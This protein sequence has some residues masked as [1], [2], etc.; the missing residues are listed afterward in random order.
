MFYRIAQES[1]NNVVKY[2]KATQVVV[3]LHM[4]E[5]GLRLSIMDDG[6]GFDVAAVPPNHL[7]LRIMRERADAVG[8]RWSIYSQPGEGTQVT[9]AWTKSESQK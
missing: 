3:G 2:A 1:L 8:A 9:L 5:D 4:Q 7:G 6:V